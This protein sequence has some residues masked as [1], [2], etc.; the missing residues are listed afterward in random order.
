MEIIP[1]IDLRGGRCVQLIQGDY[2]REMVF[3]D[4]PPA[5][6]QHWESL[7]AQRLHVVDLD[8][9]REGEPR[10][11]TVVAGI[12]RA[13]SVPVELGGGIRSEEIARGA[14][15]IGV[16]RVILGTAALDREVAEAM[17]GALG[18]SVVAGIDARDGMVAVRGWLDTTEVRALDL[19]RDL[20]SMG[21]RWVIFT[22]IARDGMLGGPNV[23]A[24]REMVEG[25]DASV[26]A[27]GGI[28]SVADLH[29]V[30]AA[31]A[32]GA[33]IGTALYKGE[34]DLKEALEAAC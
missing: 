12:C 29:A 4:D 28:K 32:A 18:E 24:L 3:G 27:S 34:I 33:I 17:I 5:I 16:D 7:G 21:I 26:I 23:T 6:A 20:V 19:A 30:R 31:G 11:L 10:N 25:V 15:D 14:L 1:A 13:V 2:E 9:A 8:G 22:D